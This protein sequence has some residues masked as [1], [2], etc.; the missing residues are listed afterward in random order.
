M[1]T[2]YRVIKRQVDEEHYEPAH[3]ELNEAEY[4]P[5][6]KRKGGTKELNRHLRTRDSVLT[7]PGRTPDR[8]II[9]AGRMHRR[10]AAGIDRAQGERD[11]IR[12]ARRERRRA[13]R[14]AKQQR[15]IQVYRKCG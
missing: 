5:S 6:N 15:N 7:Q 9:K 13:K 4:V 3:P 8:G 14:R 12:D 10:N 2:H 11:E 1:Q